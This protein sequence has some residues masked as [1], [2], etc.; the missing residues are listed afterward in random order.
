MIYLLDTDTVSFALRGV[1]EVVDR[2]RSCRPSAVAVSS[3]TVAELRYGACR[4][5]S[6]KLHSTIDAFVSSVAVVAFDEAAADRFGEIAAALVDAGVPIGDF[7][8]LI[9]AQAMALD[10]TLVTGNLRHFGRVPGLRVE[11]W[12]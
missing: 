11:R 7:D 12:G 1:P 6:R 4:R 5:R 10:M 3:L 2:L 8:A 9:A